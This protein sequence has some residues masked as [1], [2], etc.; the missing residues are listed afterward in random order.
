MTHRKEALNDKSCVVECFFPMRHTLVPLSYFCSI[1][2]FRVDI[3]MSI[4]C[5]CVVSIQNELFATK[6]RHVL[7]KNL[8]FVFYHYNRQIELVR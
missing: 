2:K 7:D 5:S 1:Q 3:E 4:T 8:M 6:L